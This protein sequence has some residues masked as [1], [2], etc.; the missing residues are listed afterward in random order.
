[1]TGW[2]SGLRGAKKLPDCTGP[3]AVGCTDFMCAQ[4]EIL[5]VGSKHGSFL[6]LFYPSEDHNLV[7]DELLKKQTFWFPRKEYSWGIAN[8]VNLPNWLFG[9]LVQW[10]V[11][12]CRYP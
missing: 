10:T 4:S 5:G 3:F 9:G 6:R 12:Q 8:F 11:G 7:G 1:M 2:F